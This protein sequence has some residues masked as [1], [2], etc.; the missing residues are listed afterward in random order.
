M[1]WVIKNK[2]NKY[3]SVKDPSFTANINQS[4]LFD[5]ELSAKNFV[6]SFELFPDFK[7]ISISYVRIVEH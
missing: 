5:D 6:A 7:N 1:P 3:F 2:E 4:H